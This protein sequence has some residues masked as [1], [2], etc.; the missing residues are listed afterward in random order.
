MKCMN[1][2][3]LEVTKCRK[4]WKI[5]KKPWGRGWEWKR[6]CLGDEQVQTNRERLKKWETNREGGLNRTFSNA[7]QLRYRE[8]SRKLLREVLRKWSSTAEVSSKY[9]A[10]RNQFQEQKLDRSTRCRGVIEEAGAFSI[11]PLGIEEVSRLR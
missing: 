1:K 11:N 4:T 9:R 3:G 5:L 10:T 6:E 7:W 2:E 8:V